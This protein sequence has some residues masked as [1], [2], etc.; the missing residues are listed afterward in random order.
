[1]GAIAIE[2]SRGLRLS[3]IIPLPARDWSF[4]FEPRVLV[5]VRGMQT[6]PDRLRGLLPLLYGLTAGGNR[7]SPDAIAASRRTS[8]GTVPRTGPLHLYQTWREPPKRIGFTHQ[9]VALIGC[10]AKAQKPVII[11]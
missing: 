10:G 9:P 1:L 7:Q 4:G 3:W 6:N 5:V 11:A 8:I 2:D